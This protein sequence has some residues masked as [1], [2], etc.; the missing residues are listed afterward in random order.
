MYYCT[1]MIQL[2]INAFS[3]LNTFLKM[4]EIGRSLEEVYCIIMC[5]G[6]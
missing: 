3:L 6:I 4:A 1:A 5:H 2:A